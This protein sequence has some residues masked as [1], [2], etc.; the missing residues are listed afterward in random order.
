M[1]KLIS[2]FSLL[3][4][5]DFLFFPDSLVSCFSFFTQDAAKSLIE[6]DTFYTMSL[7]KKGASHGFAPKSSVCCICNCLLTKN[8]VT[9][10][11]RIFNCGHAIHLHC[12]ASEVDSSSKGSSSGC[13]IC[14]PNQKPQ[15]SRNKSIVTENG[16]VNRFS[17]RRQPPHYGSTIHHHDNDLSEN[18]Y[19]GQ[20]QISRVKYKQTST[21]FD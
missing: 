16:L 15:K 3:L 5:K 8:A 20:Q 2:P 11:I 13:P 9:T 18:M 19:G 21:S 14:L 7:L 4:F 10:G 17:S 12:E 6:D 1:D